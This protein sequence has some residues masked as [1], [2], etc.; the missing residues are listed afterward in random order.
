MLISLFAVYNV[1]MS[2]NVDI[3]LVLA[4][5]GLL[6]GVFLALSGVAVCFLFYWRNRTREAQAL[7]Y[8]TLLV[9]LPKDNEVKIEAAEQM[10]TAIHSLKLDT[11]A[12]LFQKETAIAVEIVAKKEDIAFYVGVRR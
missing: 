12:S 3:G 1:F 7:D 10:F 11:F 5:I 9:R 6:L 4:Q 8:V 2:P